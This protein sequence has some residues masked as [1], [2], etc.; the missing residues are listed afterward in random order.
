MVVPM[1]VNFLKSKWRLFA[2]AHPLAKGVIA[3]SIVWPTSSF[4]QQT[5]EGKQLKDYDW[6]RILRF[7]LFGGCYVAPTLY[8]WLRVA[9]AMWPQTNLRIGALK[10]IVEQASYAPFASTSF[11]FGMT[12]LEGKGIEA[13]KA[14]VKDKFPKTLRIAIFIIPVLQTINFGLIPEPN[15]ILFVS[16]CSLFWITFLAHMQKQGEKAQLDE[17]MPKQQLKQ[18]QHHLP[19][20]KNES[21][22]PKV[23]NAFAL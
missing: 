12:M 11:Y 9:S 23:N 19:V 3:Y 4:M 7:G 15:R 14:E 2:S 8:G 16:F 22:I 1:T 10:A 18:F 17:H 6:M 5:L 13:A 21:F 20:L